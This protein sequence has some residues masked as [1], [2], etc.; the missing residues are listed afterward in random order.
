MAKKD[1]LKKEEVKASNL[2][3]E[4]REV[5]SEVG[6]NMKQN[7][8]QDLSELKSV[9]RKLLLNPVVVAVAALALYVVLDKGVIYSFGFITMAIGLT[10]FVKSLKKD[11]L[12]KLGKTTMDAASDVSSSAMKA[13]K[14]KATEIKE[15]AEQKIKES[16]DKKTE[17]V[18][19][20]SKEK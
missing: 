5:A 6:T 17:T 13:A 16:K 4:L 3:S 19:S 10:L 18:G 7:L 8:K 11:H 2:K 20:E 15:K 1:S 12:S 9:D 14:E